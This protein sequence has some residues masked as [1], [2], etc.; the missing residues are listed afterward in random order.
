[1]L[2]FCS[3]DRKT[4][5]IQTSKYNIQNSKYNIQNSKYNIQNSKYT[6]KILQV[7]YMTVFHIIVFY[8]GMSKKICT[9][10]PIFIHA[11]LP[12]AQL[13]NDCMGVLFIK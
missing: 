3:Q 6:T 9:F 5:N 10:F 13:L 1:M 11:L 8:F 4:V 7:S 12:I 2:L